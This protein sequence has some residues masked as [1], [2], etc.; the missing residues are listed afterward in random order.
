MRVAV[1]GFGHLGN[2]HAQKVDKHPTAELVGIVDPSIARQDA[3][4]DAGFNVLSDWRNTELDALIVAAPTTEHAS[5]CEAALNAGL[6]VLV[7]KPLTTT[8]KEAEHLV[9]L[10]KKKSL[11]LQVGHI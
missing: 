1:V 3:A 9:A 4:R 6:H 2:Y 10:A 5:I 8:V 11:I 7:E